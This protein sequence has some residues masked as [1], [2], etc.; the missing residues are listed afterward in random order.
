MPNASIR[1]LLLSHLQVPSC[2]VLP[3]GAHPSVSEFLALH[4][5]LFPIL[6]LEL[7]DIAG[8]RSPTRIDV[9]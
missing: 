4:L 8:V 1:L 9:I 7:L 2:V 6:G 5:E 3:L